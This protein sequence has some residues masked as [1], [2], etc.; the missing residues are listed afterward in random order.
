[1]QTHI[2]IPPWIRNDVQASSKTVV[3]FNATVLSVSLTRSHQEESLVILTL[4]RSCVCICWLVRSLSWLVRSFG[5][6]AR[7]VLL[8]RL[9][10]VAA[11]AAAAAIAGCC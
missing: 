3:G 5:S 9:A 4:P 1:M 7:R 11:A 8:P 6:F 2:L 10:A